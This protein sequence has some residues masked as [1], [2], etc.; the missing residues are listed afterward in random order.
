MA[1]EKSG[2][3]RENQKYKAL[4]VAKYLLENSDPDH[5]FNASDISDYLMDEYGI[6]AERKS[7]HR[8]IAALRDLFDLDIE[9]V[10]G[11]KIRLLSRQFE[12]NDLRLLAEC[13]HAA[14][15]ISAPKAKE[16]VSI[17][18]EFCSIYQA[19]QLQQEVFLCDRV[20]TTQ[21]GTM[22]IIST[23]NTAMAK[24]LDGKPHTPQK[25]T[26]KYMTHSIS[27][28][29]SQV[30]RHKGATYKVSPYK[31]LI[32]DGNYYLLAFS[33]RSQEM[34]TYRIDRMKDVKPCNEPREGAKAFAEIDLKT[35]TQR[36]FS[37]FGG[38]QYRVSVQFINRLLDTAIERFG[39]S[40]DVFYRPEGAEHFV[41]TADIEISKQFFG[42]LL[43][44]GT[45]AKLIGPE[46]VVQQF[47]DYLDQI[48]T[49]Y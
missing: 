40:P 17:L 6:T 41:V 23:I 13:V 3:K 10:R 38:E 33:D 46:S 43:G 18:G 27:D 37:M 31:L 34:H 8:D 36:V 39:T 32:N 35:Y 24:K 29:H 4:L 9:T 12:F 21:K 5:P 14:K 48:R 15:F 2:G 26:F 19:E 20:K 28:V 49:T 16:L 11:G 47:R 1:E 25:I 44:F 22:T 7:I 30:E 45:D 42:W